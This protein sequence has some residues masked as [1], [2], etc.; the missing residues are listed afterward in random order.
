MVC[1][2][3]YRK[4]ENMEKKK[5]DVKKKTK[6]EEKYKVISLEK[7]QKIEMI[8][9]LCVG[10]AFLVLLILSM[11]NT[12]FLPATLISF[13]LFLFCICYYYIEDESKK[14]LV[15]VLFGLGVLLIII[16]VIYTL[17]KVL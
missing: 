15:Y 10:L 9:A 3:N 8:I 2:K 17:V 16:E 14:K 1:S 4:G 7:F 12:V 11:S 13:A 6:K 5:K